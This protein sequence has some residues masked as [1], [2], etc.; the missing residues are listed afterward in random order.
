[1]KN[2]DV[3]ELLITRWRVFAEINNVILKRSARHAFLMDLQSEFPGYPSSLVCDIIEGL[4]RQCHGGDYSYEQNRFTGSTTLNDKLVVYCDKHG[5]SRLRI[6]DHLL[7]FV[8]NQSPSGCQ[9]CGRLRTN[10]ASIIS[11][12]E[13]IH[14]SSYDYRLV[15]YSKIMNKVD[16]ICVA[17][18]FASRPYLLHQSM[19]SHINNSKGCYTCGRISAGNRN[20]VPF[21]TVVDRSI[22]IHGDKYNYIRLSPPTRIGGSQHLVYFC[23]KCNT[24][25]TQRLDSHLE[26]HGCKKCAQRGLDLSSTTFPKRVYFIKIIDITDAN[27][28]AYKIG[29]TKKNMHR[30]LI[31]EHTPG[32]K[33]EI[34][35][36]RLFDNGGEAYRLEQ[37]VINTFGQYQYQGDLRLRS[38]SNT[39]MF[40][41]DGRDLIMNY[42]NKNV[43]DE[44]PQRI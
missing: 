2:R 1:M 3:V 36:D 26:G 29:C 12:A 19:N 38:C 14:G 32:I 23:R 5:E 4:S 43:V 44:T 15:K 42:L 39:E 24:E 35:Y 18:R 34:L 21:D 41:E 11:R 6:I 25:I 27:R 8:G 17:C 37:D 31:T 9:E 10:T 13:L 40:S 7:S 16:I 33:Y 30:R 20:A 22:K 28:V